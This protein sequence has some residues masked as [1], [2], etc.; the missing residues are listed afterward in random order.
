MPNINLETKIAAPVNICFDCARNIDLHQQSVVHTKEIAIAGRT[1]GLIEEGETVTWQA[2]HFG[3]KQTLTVKIEAMVYPTYFCD[4]MINGAFKSMR[5]EHFFV[6]QNN[7]CVMTDKF[8]YT[9]PLGIFG[10]IFDKIFL[11]NYLRKFLLTRNNFI[12]AEAEKQFRQI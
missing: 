2:V 3:V 10:K 8:S 5:H 1:S 7:F 6:E 9:T 4:V 11:E 12:K